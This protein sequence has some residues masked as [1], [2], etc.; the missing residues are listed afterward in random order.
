MVFRG[1]YKIFK[2]VYRVRTL[3]VCIHL[4]YFAAFQATHVET[5]ELKHIL[6]RKVK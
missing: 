2:A 1:H 6:L 3:E 4:T 5:R